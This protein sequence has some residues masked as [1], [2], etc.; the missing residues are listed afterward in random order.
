MRQDYRKK[1]FLIDIFILNILAPAALSQKVLDPISTITVD[2]SGAC[3][4]TDQNDNI[5]F[6]D[7]QN[8]Q[9]KRFTII[10]LEDIFFEEE[11]VILS[12]YLR[13]KVQTLLTDGVSQTLYIAPIARDIARTC[14]QAET[15]PDLEAAAQPWPIIEWK[16]NSTTEETYTNSPNISAYITAMYGSQHRSKFHL[17]LIIFWKDTQ[18]TIRHTVDDIQF[19]INYRH[20]PGRKA[21]NIST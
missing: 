10:H 18:A 3:A 16:I 21:S 13:Y 2:S 15:L 6:Y 8:P 17:S 19:V 9:G 5:A 11:V 4:V 7:S 1:R 20:Y 14:E 12:A